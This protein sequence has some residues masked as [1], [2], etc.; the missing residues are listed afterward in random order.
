[1]GSAEIVTLV[2]NKAYSG[3]EETTFLL[4]AFVVELSDWQPC[5]YR[6]IHDFAVLFIGSA[7]FKVIRLVLCV[8]FIVHVLACGFYRVKVES[9]SPAAVEDFFQ[10]RGVNAQVF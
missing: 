7:A 4:Q 8:L 3:F 9:G 2:K 6:L 1:M 5:N 10:S